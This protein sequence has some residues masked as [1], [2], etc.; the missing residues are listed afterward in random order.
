M[1]RSL[2]IAWVLALLLI[3]ALSARGQEQEDKTLCGWEFVE[4]N[5]DFGKSPFFG[6]FYFEHDNYH[7]RRFDNWYTRT[8]VGVKILPWLKAG[9]GYDFVRGADYLTHNAMLDVIGTLKQGNLTVSIR[10]RLVHSW[11][12]ALGT[13]GNI[14]RSRLKVQY[15]IPD[16]RWSPYLAMEMFSWDGWKRVRN[17][18]ACNYNIN[19]KVQLE[20]YYIYYIFNGA[21]DRHVIGLGVNF[22]L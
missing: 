1:L 9:V 3:P 20:G 21:P 11:T 19:E 15:A 14:L 4:L 2:H 10:E 22:Y 18:V 8:I 7:Y 13:Q 12:P 17:Y 6:S 5:H 16:T